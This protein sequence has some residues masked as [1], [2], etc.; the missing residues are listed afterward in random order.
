MYLTISDRTSKILSNH[1]TSI[2]TLS[3]Q[4]TSLSNMLASHLLT[5]ETGF[6]QLEEILDHT[7]ERVSSW[8]KDHRIWLV[9]GVLGFVIG[10]STG[11]TR[12]IML[13]MPPMTSTKDRDHCVGIVSSNSDC[14]WN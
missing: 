11:L 8:N 1:S 10:K 6:D 14:I 3:T 2:A 12:W 7:M 5:F 13:G 9:T 4:I